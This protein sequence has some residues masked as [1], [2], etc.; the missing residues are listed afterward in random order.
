MTSLVAVGIIPARGGSK[1]L[2]G[3][4]LRLLGGRPLIAYTIADA[5]ESGV[6]DRV[7]VSTDS[8]EIARTARE[9]GAE[10]PF[11][12]PAEL[13]RDDTPT[14]P[15]L[16]HVLEELEA[17]EGYRPDLAVVLQPTSPLR[18]P[19]AVREAVAKMADPRVDSVVSVCPAEHS[20]YL[21]RRLE[22]E[23]L[24]PAWHPDPLRQGLRRQELSP[25]YRLNG[26][27]YI[28]RR[29][30]LMGADPYGD[31]VRALV[32]ERWRSVDIDAE[33]DLLVAEAYLQRFCRRA[34]VR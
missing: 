23:R 7:I 21:M 5:R 19:E 14:I 6:L 12:R 25:L 8:E 13:A 2:P 1:G 4:N 31:E 15:V 11:L 22:G 18:G 29:E 28:F 33:E 27:V 10:V 3:K 17:R 16:R 30:R 34:G 32:M 20:P 24:V 9:W 26:A